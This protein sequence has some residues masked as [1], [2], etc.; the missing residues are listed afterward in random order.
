MPYNKLYCQ[1][2]KRY[3]WHEVTD[4]KQPDNPI[5]LAVIKQVKE[6]IAHKLE[7][8][9]TVKPEEITGITDKYIPGILGVQKIFCPS[10]NHLQID[11]IINGQTKLKEELWRLYE[12]DRVVK[13]IIRDR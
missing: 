4:H 1:I 5:L 13:K 3:R 12:I 11:V 8:I 2:E 10:C 6:D 9:K 7:Q